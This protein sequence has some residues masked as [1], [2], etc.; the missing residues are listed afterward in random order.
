MNFKV[1]YFASLRDKAG[2]DEER[3]NSSA[4]DA[5]ALYAQVS[6]RHGFTI[7]RDRLRVAVNG[8]FATW[9][10]NLDDGDE[11]VFLPPVSGG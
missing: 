5:E 4:V 9:S 6:A 2:C 8:N 11:V 1:L 7:A 10:H 3:V